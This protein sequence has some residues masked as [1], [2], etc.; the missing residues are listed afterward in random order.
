MPPIISRL[1][2]GLVLAFLLALPISAQDRPTD[3]DGE[4]GG[5]QTVTDEEQRYD[6]LVSQF[7]R[8]YLRFTTLIQVVPQIPLEETSG[9]QE[10][11]SIPNARFGVAGRLDAGIG[12]EVQGDFAAI[13]SLLD[14]F[15]SYAPSQGTRFLVGRAKVPFSYEFLT[16]AGSID[17]VNRARAVSRLVP[18]RQI[19]IAARSRVSGEALVLRGGLFNTPTNRPI[20]NTQLPQSQRGGLTLAARVQSTTQPASGTTLTVGGNLA[21]ITADTAENLDLPSRTLL[22]ADARLRSGR[23]VLAAEVVAL[24]S[25]DRFAKRDGFHLTTGVDVT[26]DTRALVRLDHF[27]ASNDVLLGLNHSLTRA[28]AVQANVLLPTES[29]GRPA[30][31]LFNAQLS[32]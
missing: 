31:F 5:G 30:Q 24:T 29:D 14:A 18:A 10:N 20:L 21:Y 26:D 9:L 11:F 1:C 15:V 7:Q 23:L 6:R 17:F 4:A 12:Y 25:E 32:F 2:G 22:G 27:E 19:G 8:E 3:G 28:A 13:P 16:G